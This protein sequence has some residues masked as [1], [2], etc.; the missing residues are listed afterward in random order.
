MANPHRHRENIAVGLLGF[1]G[2]L[3]RALQISAMHDDSMLR[4]VALGQTR[5]G[6]SDGAHHRAVRG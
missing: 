2:E 4:V 3:I 6:L 5:D 1:V